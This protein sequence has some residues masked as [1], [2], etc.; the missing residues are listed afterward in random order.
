[1]V[2]MDATTHCCTL[3]FF[4]S[5]RRHTRFSRDWSSDV[6][7]SD[8][9]YEYYSINS[10]PWDGP[11]GVVMCDGKFAACALDRN[12]LRPARWTLSDDGVFVIAS[13]TGVWDIAPGR[14]KAKGKLGPGEMI[15]VDLVGNALLD[16]DA[17][18]AI[19]RS[20]APYKQWLKRGMTYLHTELIDPALTDAPFGDDTL[21]GFQK[22]F[23]LT[24]EEQEA[25]LRP[26]AETEQEAIGS[27]GDDIP[28]AAISQRVRP[29]YDCFRQAFAQV[30]NPPI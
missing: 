25:V 23:Q 19:N 16:N 13:E 17:I 15:A 4:S 21:L 12:G 6:C 26:L 9:F 1:V 3:F 2:D 10:E 20:R 22:L 24:R 8:L 28:M 14:V 11:A 7:S 18:D 29:L 5:R 27:M 30:T